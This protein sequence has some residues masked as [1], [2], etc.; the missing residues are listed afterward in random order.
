MRLWLTAMACVLAQSAWGQVQV[1]VSIPLPT[2]T[3]TAPP[4][5]VVVQPGV[6]VVEDYEEEVFFVD[7]WYWCRR[8]GHW[9]RTKNHR[10]GW[11]VVNA[12]VPGSLVA[13]PPGQ[14]R[15]WKRA[16]HQHHGHGEGKGRGKKAK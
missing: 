7:G 10:G 13:L 3:F 2:V 11:V 15:K 12:G 9:F 14:F 16:A 8:E 5:L 4:V 1:Q 6:Q